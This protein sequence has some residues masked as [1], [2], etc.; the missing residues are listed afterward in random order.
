MTEAPPI[1]CALALIELEPESGKQ[2]GC[3]DCGRPYA[4]GP[5]LVVSHEDWARIAPNPPTAG[6]LCPNCMHDRF[7]AIGAGDGTIRAV[8]RSGPFAEP[9]SANETE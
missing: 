9:E 8:F 5:D 6:V 4:K 3:Y 2:L 1:N 7:V